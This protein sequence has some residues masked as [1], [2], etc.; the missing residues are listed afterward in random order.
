MLV[1][2]LLLESTF[3]QNAS[4]AGVI[5]ALD[6]TPTAGIRVA[7]R[8]VPVL[9]ATSKEALARIGQTDRT[10]HYKLEDILP[11]RYY[12]T[13][14]LLDSPTYYPGVSS[15]KEAQIVEVGPGSVLVNLDF[16]LVQSPGAGVSGR[17]KGLAQDTLGDM[18]VVLMPENLTY[19]PLKILTAIIKEDGTFEFTGI[20]NGRYALRVVRS[21]FASTI[22]APYAPVV[23]TFEVIDKDVRG[24]E[25]D[26]KPEVVR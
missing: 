24:L 2:L 26:I 25:V 14:G 1:L 23:S 15:A 9:N 8:E 17:V 20:S 12:I 19:R 11:G 22:D 21:R 13:A 3:A 18:C 4:V 10:G 7:V 5:R 6:G 16:A